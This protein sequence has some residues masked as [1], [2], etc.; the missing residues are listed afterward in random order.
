MYHPGINQALSQY[1]QSGTLA[2]INEASPHRLIQMLMEGALERIA[3]A[4]GAMLRGDVAVK[5]ERISRAIDI[6]EG[7]R[8]HLDMEKGGEIAANLEALYDYMNRQLM[9]ANLR[10][11][12]AILD[13]VSS[14]MR[15]IKTAW[16]ALSAEE[17][18]TKPPNAQPKPLPI[19]GDDEAPA[20]P[21]IKEQS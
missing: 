18:G 9:M 8:V 15:E 12:P 19:A 6:I 10:N 11:D 5:G 17:S 14:L 4:R 16:D 13:E 1:R 2:E 7:L 21:M 3:V 20:T